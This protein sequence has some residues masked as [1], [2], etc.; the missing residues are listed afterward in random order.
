MSMDLGG[1]TTTGDDGDVSKG[2]DESV[3]LS[4]EK[5]SA[6][7]GSETFMF[8]LMRYSSGCA[9]IHVSSGA[10]APTGHGAAMPK[11]PASMPNLV[12]AFPA[13]PRPIGSALLCETGVDVVEGVSQ[14]LS[15]ISGIPLY[16]SL[17]IPLHDPA[18]VAFAEGELVKKL[19]LLK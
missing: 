16:V 8:T 19:R 5:W 9:F 17:G 4:E 3:Y 10:A 7:M 1:K 14:R 2:A 18:A 11:M 12:A 6:H 15:A 13:S